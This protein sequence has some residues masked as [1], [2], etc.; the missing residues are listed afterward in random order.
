MQ[1]PNSPSQGRLQETDW[2]RVAKSGSFQDLL[3]TKRAFIVPAFFTFLAY[4]LLLPV[5]VG[6]APRLMSTKVLGTVSLAYLFALSQFVVGWAIAL[7]YLKVSSRFDQLADDALRRDVAER[8][9]TPEEDGKC[10]SL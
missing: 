2:D 1:P 7:L 5:L 9:G 8:V 3:A 4:Y 10:R 6:Y